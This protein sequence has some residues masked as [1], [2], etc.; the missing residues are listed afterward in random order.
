MKKHIVFILILT[1]I[2]IKIP[3]IFSFLISKSWV[4]IDY[5]THDFNLSI[6]LSF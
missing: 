2:G 1:N 4:N 6:K 5:L 3:Y